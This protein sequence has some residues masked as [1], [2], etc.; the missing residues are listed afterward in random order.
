MITPKVLSS[1]NKVASRSTKV[2]KVAIVGAGPGDPDLLTLRALRSIQS[3]D[4]ILYDAL[5]SDEIQAFFPE[6]AACIYVGKRKGRHAI[7]Q[8]GIN[9]LLIDQARSGLNVC[10]LKGGDPF[11]FGR[12]GEEALAATQAGIDV[13][14]V[15]GIS[16][17]HGCAASAGIP[18]THRG[19]AQGCTF[20]TAHARSEDGAERLSLNWQAL[21]TIG[22]TLVFY[23]GVSRA[24]SISQ[25]LQAHGMAESTPVA[26]IERGCTPEQRVVT[27]DLGRLA[28]DILEH[29]IKAPALI[30]VG[31]VVNLHAELN[32]IAASAIAETQQLTA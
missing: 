8:Q 15:P 6:Q 11:V 16:S 22:T 3:A 1:N 18:L 31:E 23:M 32:Q 14:V 26:I 28:R 10:R 27:T 19:V 21:A 29:Q 13:E 17:A 12:G 25:N 24:Q 4:V 5:V 2:G 7:S 9:E 20:I 30:V